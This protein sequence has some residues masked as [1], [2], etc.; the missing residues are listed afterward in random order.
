MT[1]AEL[2]QKSGLTEAE[3]K[4]LVQGFQGFLNSL[5]P[6]QRAAVDRWMPTAAHI[7]ASFGPAVTVEQLADIV[8]ADPSSSTT[9]SQRGVG[10]GAPSGGTGVGSG[11]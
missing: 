1:K 4:E 10:L 8:G 11:S 9:I 2:L 3:F 7:A 6:A 5:K